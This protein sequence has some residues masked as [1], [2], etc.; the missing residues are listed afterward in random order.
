MRL[1]KKRDRYEDKLGVLEEQSRL[2][3]NKMGFAKNEY[4]V[5]LK[6]Y[7]IWLKENEMQPYKVKFPKPLAENS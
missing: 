1:M 5:N 3:L 7:Q 4:E 2:Y 6:K